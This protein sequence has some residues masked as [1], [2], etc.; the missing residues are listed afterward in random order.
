MDFKVS[1]MGFAVGLLVGLTGMGGGAVMTPLLILLGW[2][3]PVVAV[4]TD[5]VWNAV[6]K[7]VGAFVHY[8][9]RTVDLT[10]VK[11]LALGSIPG[12]A[13][14]LL[15][16]A[17][18]RTQGANA[19]D[20]VVVRTLGVA[21]VCVA[22][23][24]FVRAFAGPLKQAPGAEPNRKRQAW[25]TTL[26]G[27]VVGFLVS[28]TSVGSGSLIVASL[29][30]IYPATPLRRIV[31]SDIFHALFLVTVAA[32]GHLR[33]GGING[34][35]LVSLLI[36]SVPG[37][38]VGSKMSAVFPEKVLRPVLATVLLFLGYKLL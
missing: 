22:L 4:G 8:R 14:G 36:G 32:A 21:L 35:L 12:A 34:H 28:M 3:R 19:M 11:R 20:R 2:A 13:S 15:L 31:G 24:L 1:A 7:G 33:M 26:V 16:L 29:V 38:W 18:L 30:V 17:Y 5:L 10:I 27:A 25:L 37:V 23:S 6:T 9:Q